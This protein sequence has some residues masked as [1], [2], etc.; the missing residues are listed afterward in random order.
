MQMKKLC[1]FF[2]YQY[3]NLTLW[4]KCVCTDYYYHCR[5]LHVQVY[6][7]NIGTQKKSL[8][9]KNA[10]KW[11]RVYFDVHKTNMNSY[12]AFVPHK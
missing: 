7:K 8:D 12:F 3:L 2:I 6:T 4:G 5:P 1:I 9:D 11:E 10:I